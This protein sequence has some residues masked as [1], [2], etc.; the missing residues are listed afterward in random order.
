MYA[1]ALRGHDG[2]WLLARIRRSRAG[3]VYFLIPRDDPDW[4]PHASYHRSGA[5]LLRSYKG[6]HVS[7]QRQEPDASFQGVETVLSLAIQ[8]GEADLHR[9]PCIPDEFTKVFE[10]PRVQFLANEHHT[11]AVDLVEPGK[12]AAP[13]PWKDIVVQK[14]FQDAYLG[15]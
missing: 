3:D 2:L 12:N 6:K 11:L 1:V 9:T 5:S 15:F 13:G 4:N 8:L 10:I 14:S 7:S